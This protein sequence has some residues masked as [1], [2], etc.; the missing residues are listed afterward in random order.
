MREISGKI[1]NLSPFQRGLRFVI[2]LAGLVLFISFFASGYTPPGIAG[3][4]LR[5]NRENEIDASPL[6]YT[7]LE[8]I[9]EILDDVRQLR[10][11]ALTESAEIDQNRN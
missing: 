6:I 1:K 8:N 3:E 11:D 9:N 5:H 2:G 10:Q 7:D 4:V